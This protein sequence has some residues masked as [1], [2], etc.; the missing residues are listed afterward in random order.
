MNVGTIITTLSDF[1][2]KCL[3]IGNTKYVYTHHI[4]K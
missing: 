3:K 4:C 2:H 1:G